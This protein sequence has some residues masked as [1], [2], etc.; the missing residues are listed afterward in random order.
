MVLSDAEK[1]PEPIIDLDD[2]ISLKRNIYWFGYELP[3]II[4][5]SFFT[6]DILPLIIR[7]FVRLYGII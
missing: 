5:T 7:V 1:F 2:R 6:S 4:L 3:L